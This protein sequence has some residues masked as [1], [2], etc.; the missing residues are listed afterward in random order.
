M[1]KQRLAKLLIIIAALNFNGCSGTAENKTP[2]APANA[3]SATST[4]TAG[5]AATPVPSVPA[6]NVAATQPSTVPT[7]ESRNAGAA[8][9]VNAPTP[10]IGS[11]G[12]D[13]YLFTQARA[14]VNADAELKAAN[15]IVEVKEGI[16]TLNGTVASAALK[17]KAEELVRGVKP[18]DVKNQL[19]VAAGK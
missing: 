13:F 3:N 8:P 6:A 10:Q 18:K 9:P 14:A 7:S 12:N 17:A 4:P 5:V 19:R 2:I 16:V 1:N 15:L 11:G